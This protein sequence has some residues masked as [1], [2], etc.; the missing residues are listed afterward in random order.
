MFYEE[1]KDEIKQHLNERA[2]HLKEYI[3]S[4]RIAKTQR[5][6][7]DEEKDDF[8][9]KILQPLIDTNKEA[10]LEILTK[11]DVLRGKLNN[12]NDKVQKEAGEE[13]NSE[14]Q[15]RVIEELGEMNKENRFISD[16]ASELMANITAQLLLRAMHHDRIPKTKSV[17]SIANATPVESIA[18]ATPV[19]SIANA[20]PVKSNSTVGGKYKK[21]Y[22]KRRKI[23]KNKKSKKTKKVKN[24]KGKKQKR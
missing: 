3:L 9:T 12:F 14:A 8:K 15:K 13:E 1:H 18:N 7:R 5:L 11:Y 6:K 17:E 2:P 21:I 23:K 24:K 22:S 4:P 10:V 19:E 20:T 16:K